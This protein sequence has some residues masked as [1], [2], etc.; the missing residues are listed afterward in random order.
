M[1]VLSKCHPSLK[2]GERVLRG[3]TL[4]RVSAPF[5]PSERHCV[6]M[7]AWTATVPYSPEL[8]AKTIPE[9]ELVTSVPL[10]ADQLRGTPRGINSALSREFLFKIKCILFL[11][12]QRIN[13]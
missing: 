9:M 1:S 8:K 4:L 12:N 2:G 11:L 10:S 7:L 6:K 3:K 13:K 5:L